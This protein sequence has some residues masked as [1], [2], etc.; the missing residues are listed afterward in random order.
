MSLRRIA[1]MG[2]RRIIEL[3]SALEAPSQN[4]K[5]IMWEIPCADCLKYWHRCR[6]VGVQ[7]HICEPSAEQIEERIFIDAL[8]DNVVFDHIGRFRLV[9][10]APKPAPTSSQPAP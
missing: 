2:L 1:A 4:P 10:N 9:V 7:F 6:E 3:V 8:A 5:C